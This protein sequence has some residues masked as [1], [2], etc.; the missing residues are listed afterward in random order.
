MKIQYKTAVFLEL[1]KLCMERIL[2]DLLAG[3]VKTEI[4]VIVS[5]TGFLS[6][7]LYFFVES[8]FNT[9]LSVISRARGVPFAFEESFRPKILLN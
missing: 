7:T 4:P 8:I 2:P 5:F 3:S 9:N 1:L 6:I